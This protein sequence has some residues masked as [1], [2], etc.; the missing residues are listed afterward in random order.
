M[1]LFRWTLCLGLFAAALGVIYC[2]Y[3]TGMVEKR[4]AGRRWNIP[5][6]IYSDTWLLYPGMPLTKEDVLTRL[7]ATGYRKRPSGP[8]AQGEY[9]SYGN[10]L[11]VNFPALNVPGKKRE[12]LR[13][14]LRFDGRRLASMEDLVSGESLP[15]LELEPEVLMRYF[16]SEREIRDVVAV[17]QIPE[18]LQHAVLAAEDHRF[19]GHVGIDLRGIARAFVTNLRHGTIR[20]GGSTLTQQLAK[21]YFLS[22]ERTL[23]RKIHEVFIA[24]AIEWAFEKEEILGIYL[25]EI[26]FGQKGSASVNGVGAAARFYFDKNVETLTLAES[27]T[28]AGLIKGPNLYSPYKNRKRSRQRR[29]VVLKSMERYGWIDKASLGRALASPIKTVGYKSYKRRAPYFLDYVSTQLRQVYPETELTQNGYSVYTT[30]DSRV[31]RAAEKALAKGLK[32]LERN[33][34]KLKR[35]NPAAR[36]QGAIVV[37]Q[38]RT[39]NILAMVGGRDYAVSQFNRATQALRQPGSCMKPLAAS[40]LLDRFTPAERFS[41]DAKTYEVNGKTWQPK[42]FAKEKGGEISMREMLTISSNR[43]AVDMVDKGGV[44]LVARRLKGFGFKKSPPALPSVVLGASE[45]TPLEL[46]RAYAVFASDG[47]APFP[48][49]LKD[50]VNEE[51]EVLT[52]RFMDVAPVITPGEAFLVTSMLESVVQKGTGKSLKRLGVQVPV[53]GKTGTTNRSR[54]AWFVAYTPELLALVWIGFDNNA[55]TGVTGGRGALPIWAD[56]V[57]AVPE[58]LSGNSFVPPP[59]VITRKV[60]RESGALAK[61]SRCPNRVSEVFV[62]TLLPTGPCPIHGKASFLERVGET[63]KSVFD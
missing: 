56:L 38:P 4:F 9:L 13:A 20:Q 1:K 24:L 48:L 52:G 61:G 8:L 60:C 19:F 21:N 42:N 50:V 15:L 10:T 40:V 27:A 3:L 58:Y 44:D 45:V 49:S 41:N 34:P 53:A 35:T 16:G 12:A 39:G 28:L 11:E 33:N 62:E 18:Y 29:D 7:S 2:W 31:Q 47:I 32:R 37:M 6:V 25:N 59:D 57:K 30:L 26:Y 51:G 63:V 55:S 43:A 17:D 36:L 5:S 22:S 14:G 46:A 54:D 23:K